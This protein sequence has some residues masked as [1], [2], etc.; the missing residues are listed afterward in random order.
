MFCLKAPAVSAGAFFLANGAVRKDWSFSIGFYFELVESAIVPNWY[1]SIKLT[2]ERGRKLTNST[3]KKPVK[4]RKFN[5]HGS[6]LRADNFT[7]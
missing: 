6:K 5:W 1:S 7:C 4:S 2:R 3:V